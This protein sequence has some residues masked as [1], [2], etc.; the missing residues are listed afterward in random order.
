MPRLRRSDK[1]KHEVTIE[2]LNLLANMHCGGDSAVQWE[3][4]WG[5]AAEGEA[6]FDALRDD[7]HVTLGSTLG[8][9]EYESY[10]EWLARMPED[11]GSGDAAPSPRCG[12]RSDRRR[13]GVKPRRARR[14][15]P[16]RTRTGLEP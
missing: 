2:L 15:R 4:F 1:R 16:R 3:Q 9:R 6:A 11:S 10:D 12:E 14:E 8:V 5:G 7:R 13:R